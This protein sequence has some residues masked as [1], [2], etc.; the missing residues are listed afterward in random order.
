MFLL[1]TLA[2]LPQII[3]GFAIAH[4][5]W[6][7]KK[8]SSILLK[9]SI[10]IPL[11]MGMESIILFFSKWATLKHQTYIIIESMFIVMIFV[12][13]FM[14]RRNAFKP[15]TYDINVESIKKNRSLL[16]IL[17]LATII[18]ITAFFITVFLYPHGREDAWS[19][20]NL[21]ARFIYYSNNLSNALDYIARSSFPG[22][23]FMLS[24]NVAS[25]WIFMG[26]TTTRIPIVLAGLFTFSIPAILF[27]G[28]LKNKGLQTASIA[29]IIIM[30]PWLAQYGTYLMSDIPMAAFY[31]ATTVM[32]SIYYSDEHPGL[33]IL[34]GMLAG[35][36][37]WVKNDG[38]PF[39]LSTIVVMMLISLKKRNLSGLLQFALGLLIPLTTGFT[40]R[41]FLAAPGN[42]VTSASD[43]L[44]KL[45]DPVRIQTV[46]IFF[47][48]QTFFFSNPAYAYTLIL[49]AILLLGGIDTKS[50]NAF[51]TMLIFLMQYAAYFA[52]YL[53]TPL[54]LGW[55]LKTS[56]PRVFAQIAP[57][58]V[59]AIFNLLKERNLFPIYQHSDTVTSTPTAE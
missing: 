11:G 22:Y 31:I 7:D 49:L 32:I 8:L 13:T 58:L 41:H 51:F 26:S 59:F 15:I 45:L 19:N 54:D 1:A 30:A 42:I 50:T 2:L 55:H 38:Q 34:A 39:V 44:P 25:G 3:F 52:V 37:S 10:G 5:V 21:V 56:M 47:L 29:A 53:I 48:K 17:V 6:A 46:F 43:M 28:L 14:V 40:Y 57:L 35:F 12:A 36:S 33:A 27:L 4:L 23:P 24:L 9:L 20:W 16:L 18:S